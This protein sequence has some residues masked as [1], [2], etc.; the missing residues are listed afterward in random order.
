MEIGLRKGTKADM[1]AVHALVMELAVFERAP[2]Q[3]LTTP[4]S[5]AEDGFG[6]RPLFESLVAELDGQVVGAAVYF[7][8]YSTW[9]GKGLYLDDL[10][11][12]A[13]LRGKGIGTRLF[14]ALVAEARAAGARQL[15]W[16]VLNW[17]APAIR[18]YEKYHAHFDAE[19]VNCK[20]DPL[21][22]EYDTCQP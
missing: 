18:F 22:R 16:Q 8:K 10:V 13:A 19:W 1:P 20:I 12:T 7:F 3:V 2:E 5:M 15:H 14:N 17:N 9:K 21:A 11:V 4:A 6:N